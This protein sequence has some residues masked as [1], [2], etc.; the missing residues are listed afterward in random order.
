M[1][2][3]EVNRKVTTYFKKNAFIIFTLIITLV[4]LIMLMFYYFHFKGTGLSDSTID[5]ANFGSY[6]GSI[7][8]LLA[9]AGV[10]YTASLSEKR[11]EKAEE[12]MR[13]RE[14]REQF[15]KLLE[16]L[17]SQ[18]VNNSSLNNHIE[19]IENLLL[20]Y[21]IEYFIK[22]I[23]E[24]AWKN[25]YTQ[26]NIDNE[27]FEN[28]SI[29]EQIV[30]LFSKLN[31]K[32]QHKHIDQTQIEIEIEKQE[33]N[34]TFLKTHITLKD[35]KNEERNLGILK[36]NN[37]N[38]NFIQGLLG[39]LESDTPKKIFY[40]IIKK[41][42]KE[43]YLSF[44]DFIKFCKTCILILEHINNCSEDTRGSYL[45]ILRSQLKSNE[46][47]LLFLYSLTEYSS[48]TIIQII[49]DNNVFSNICY[50]DFILINDLKFK[51]KEG[52]YL[53]EILKCYLE[54]PN[55]K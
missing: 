17:Q 55:N 30:W 50:D 5:W 25:F 47:I 1:K 4:A 34:L 39:C 10:L 22:N 45:E 40:E 35:I 53:I 18:P 33:I 46:L 14:E 2:S 52:D 15:F 54:D 3:L 43:F 36:T 24:I 11:A 42:N 38:R 21:I 13:K 49:I 41:S 20:I 32:Y 7:T 48:K 16:L 6:F 26:Y 44:N 37:L 9:F 28:Q 8:G 23:S 51:G 12:E 31:R 29:Y 19:K 27:P